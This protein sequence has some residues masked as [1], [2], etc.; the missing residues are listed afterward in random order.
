MTRILRIDSSA[1]STGSV[2]RDLADQIIARFT[3][4]TPTE[5]AT[6]DLADGL[7]LL[8]EAWVGANFTPEADRTPDQRD[9]L[10]L[11]DTL[12]A[13]L[14]A[15]DVIVIGLPIYNFGAPAA[16]K[17]W[18][19]LIA[20]AGVTFR[21]T[22]NGPE[23]LLSGKRAIIALASGGVE[24]GSPVDFASTHLRQVLNF[25]G[26]TDVSI[27]RADLMSVDAEAATARTAADLA[28]LEIAA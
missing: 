15:A 3:A 26:I 20:R 28:A 7:P 12:V 14:Q 1:R 22:E 25:V 6:R 9:T 16:L 27:V 11:S 8:S 13:E 10:A 21:Y 2:T 17:A 24:T 23:G 19:D 18:I 4:A 5:V